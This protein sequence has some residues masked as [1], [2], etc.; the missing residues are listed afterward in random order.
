MHPDIPDILAGTKRLS[1]AE[2]GRMSPYQFFEMLTELA[3]AM[4]DEHR[5]RLPSLEL[6]GLKNRSDESSI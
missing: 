1:A 3:Q 6:L 5:A 4:V 2:Y